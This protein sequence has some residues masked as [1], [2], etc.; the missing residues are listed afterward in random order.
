MSIAKPGKRESGPRFVLP[1]LEG[2]DGDTSGDLLTRLAENL[3][4][5][6]PTPQCV[7]VRHW[8]DAGG[9]R[10]DLPEELQQHA[11]GRC[12]LC[13]LQLMRAS[14]NGSVSKRELLWKLEPL[15]IEANRD[16]AEFAGEAAPGSPGQRDRDEPF[17]IWIE[18]VD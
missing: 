6:E 4:S 2:E 12:D 13:A 5:F 7:E 10:I 8:I 1:A 17:E 3:V 9:V 18:D 16:L 11:D 14:G 15:L